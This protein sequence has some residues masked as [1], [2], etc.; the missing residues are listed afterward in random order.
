MVVPFGPAKPA[1]S[2]PDADAARALRAL[3]GICVRT[4]GGFRPPQPGRDEWWAVICRRFAAV[5]DVPSSNTRSKLRRALRRCEVRRLAPDEL[6]RDGYD[7]YVRALERYGD[8]ASTPM[9]RRAF[10]AR[11]LAAEGYDDIVHTWGVSVDGRLAGYGET[12]LFG[13]TEA[14]YA[15]IRLDPAHLGRYTSYALLHEMNRYYLHERGVEYVNDGF[16]SILHQT[17]IQDFLVQQFGFERAYSDVRLAWRPTYGALVRLTFFAR[18]ILGRADPRMSALYELE[19][20]SR[21]GR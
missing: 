3:G 5:D 6:A 20:A 4:T 9:S 10:E 18:G 8:G 16:R 11:A 17:G 1:Y 19:H 12:Y 7:V 21:A 15:T 2:L 14:N 13:A